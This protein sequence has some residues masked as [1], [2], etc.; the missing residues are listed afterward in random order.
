[1]KQVI[2]GVS[3][4]AA[5]ASLGY[6]ATKQGH[7][8]NKRSIIVEGD[9]VEIEYQKDDMNA[10]S[11]QDEFINF[12]KQLKLD[13]NQPDLFEK[14]ATQISYNGN[15]ANMKK[16]APYAQIHDAMMAEHQDRMLDGQAWAESFVTQPAAEFKAP[17]GMSGNCEFGSSVDDH[18]DDEGCLITRGFDHTSPHI[19]NLISSVGCDDESYVPYTDDDNTNLWF[20]IPRAIPLWAKDE[21]SHESDW[22]EYFTLIRSMAT[23][24]WERRHSGIVRLSV[25]LY[26]NGVQLIP[27]GVRMTSRSP[28]ARLTRW[29]SKPSLSAQKPGFYRTLRTIADNVGKGAYRANSGNGNLAGSQENKDNCYFLMFIQDIPYDLNQAHIRTDPENTRKRT[30]DFFDHIGTKCFANYAFVMPGS[31]DSNTPAGKFIDSFRL[32]AQPGLMEYFPWDEDYSGIYRLENF[33]ELNAGGFKRTIQ[34]SMCMHSRRHQC[35]LVMPGKV[36]EPT[37]AANYGDDY[38]SDDYGSEYYTDAEVYSAVGPS[39]APYAD[40]APT[41]KSIGEDVTEP[42]PIPACCG[43]EYYLS[44]FNA[45]KKACIYDYE[46]ESRKIVSFDTLDY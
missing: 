21:D 44:V 24:W 37:V 33:Q 8:I 10:T 1:M 6:L 16:Y 43:G 30:G 34:K 35:K 45:A 36:I 28:L 23:D 18:M 22:T 42:E 12:L 14:A 2:A 13:V 31:R 20:L 46:T 19:E 7:S 41:M 4:L 25:G 39:E 29:Y 40:Y 5:L 3:G 9:D 32:I 26:L 27:R 38:Y 17:A 11:H 15:Y